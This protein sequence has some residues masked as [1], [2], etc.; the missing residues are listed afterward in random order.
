MGKQAVEYPKW[1]TIRYKK[2]ELKHEVIYNDR[3]RPVVAWGW[4]ELQGIT[5]N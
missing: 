2:N 4:G 5:R 1:N 3:N